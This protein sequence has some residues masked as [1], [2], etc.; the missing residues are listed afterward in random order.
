MDEK[1]DKAIAVTRGT[2]ASRTAPDD[3][4][5]VAQAILNLS[6]VKTLWSGFETTEEED[7]ELVFVLGKIRASSDATSLVQIT[8]AALNISNARNIQL[9]GKPKPKKTGSSAN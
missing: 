9:T 3:I 5:K 7:E 6:H 2:M 4:Q 1:I 8:Q